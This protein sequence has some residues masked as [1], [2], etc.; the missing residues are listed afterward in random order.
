MG[1]V[2]TSNSPAAP[3]GLEQ[4]PKARALRAVSQVCNFHHHSRVDMRN[5]THMHR[6]ANASWKDVDRLCHDSY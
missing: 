5:L 4:A 1:L 6:I 3:T 2:V